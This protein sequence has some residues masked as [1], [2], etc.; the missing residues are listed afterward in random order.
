M[1]AHR[2]PSIQA[3]SE[4]GVL[5]VESETCGGDRSSRGMECGEYELLRACGL[6]RAENHGG[7]APEPWAAL[8]L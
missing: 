1:E 3:G 8:D 2:R 4:L 5:E 6:R 7:A